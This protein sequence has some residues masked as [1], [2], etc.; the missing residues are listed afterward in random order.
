M[1]NL[2]D[3]TDSVVLTDATKCNNPILAVTGAWSTMCGYAREEAVGQNP[4]LTQGEQTDRT[5]SCALGEA[6]R[7]GRACKVQLLNYRKG[8]DVFW[9][10]LH[11]S[12]I[13]YAGRTVLFKGIL[14]DYSSMVAPMVKMRPSQYFKLAQCYSEKRPL[15]KSLPA[16]PVHIC[17]EDN[18]DGTVGSLEVGDPSWNS[19]GLYVKRLG[20][21][22]TNRDPEYLALWL[23][24][25]FASIGGVH[26]NAE[27]YE[28]PKCEMMTVDVAGAN[29]LRCR[30][31]VLPATTPGSFRISFER[32]QGPH[33]AYHELYRALRNHLRSI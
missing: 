31:M 26:Y 8:G 4:R 33:G 23:Q 1:A 10:V 7:A 17:V 27:V 6:V 16:H 32:L 13:E 29:G 9:N 28:T 14:K 11:V 19:V 2:D 18:A 3:D 22:S 24:D 12:P 25:A 15:L 20:W 21:E 5:V 30:A